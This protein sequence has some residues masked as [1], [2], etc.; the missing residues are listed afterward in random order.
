MFND[1]KLC[2]MI[3]SIAKDKWT[4]AQKKKNTNVPLCKLVIHMK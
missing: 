1:S 3:N 2:V 4:V